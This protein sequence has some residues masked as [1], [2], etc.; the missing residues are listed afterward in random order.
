VAVPGPDMTPRQAAS[1]ILTALLP[2][3]FRRPV[4]DAEIARYL[5]LFDKAD[6]RGDSFEQSV[7]LALK[8]VLISPS[9][10]FLVEP[11]PE[12]P[13]PYR[14]G[15]YEVA[16][17]LS[18]FLWASMPDEELFKLAAAGKLHDDKVLRAQVRRMMAD[19]RSRGLADS[20]AA[21]WLGIRPL[22]VTIR[23]DARL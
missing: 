6:Q 5:G 10:L 13:G 19:P 15:H 18:Y 21:Q 8:G 17:H 1:K 7:K 20:F 22:G 14:L 2:R 11:P 12:K 4:T 9:F 3:A 16:S 23:P